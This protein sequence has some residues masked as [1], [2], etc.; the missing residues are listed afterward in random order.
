MLV[1]MWAS[2]L[3][4]L[5]SCSKPMQRDPGLAMW[6]ILRLGIMFL[7]WLPSA[8]SHAYSTSAYHT[9]HYWSLDTHIYASLSTIRLVKNFIIS[10]DEMKDDNYANMLNLRWW[11]PPFDQSAII[12][13][14]WDRDEIPS[15]SATYF[16]TTST[17]MLLSLWKKKSLNASY[18]SMST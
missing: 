8:N 2:D 14:W 9:V 12:I 11:K 17:L 10:F 1:M 16:T 3:Y 6:Y 5:S 4:P 15:F 7:S 13:T 18:R